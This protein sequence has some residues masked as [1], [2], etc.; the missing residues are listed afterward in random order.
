MTS[1]L[2][3]TPLLTRGLAHAIGD[4]T[5]MT[6]PGLKLV[7]LGDEE[8]QNTREVGVLTQ[9]LKLEAIEKSPHSDCPF[10]L[11]QASDQD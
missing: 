5:L 9:P 8:L 6:N 4:F 1:E 2:R 3:D 10:F 11:C 7:V